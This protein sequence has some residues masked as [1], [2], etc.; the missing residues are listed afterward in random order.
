MRI[1][2]AGTPDFAVPCLRAAATRGEVVAVYTQPDR[3]AGRGRGL[4][5]PPV[6]LEAVQR[7][8]PVLQPENFKSAMSKQAL[9]ALVYQCAD[10]KPFVSCL[11]R[12]TPLAKRSLEAIYARQPEIHDSLEIRQLELDGMEVKAPGQTTWLKRSDPRAAPMVMP[13]CPDGSDAQP[14]VP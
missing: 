9:R 8:I 1:V 4:T 6:K 3:P 11:V 12:Y 10:G 14:V 7:G 5:P 2:F 13:R